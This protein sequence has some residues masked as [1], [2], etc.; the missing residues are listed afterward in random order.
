MCTGLPLRWE[1][2]MAIQVLIGATVAVHYAV[3]VFLMFGGFLAW[4]WQRVLVPH[5]LVVG[6]GLLVIAAPVSCPLTALENFFRA[7]IGRAPLDGGFID[8]YVTGVLY[9]SQD[10]ELVRWLVA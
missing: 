10:V 4:R 1:V 6:W 3:L 5:M 9:P 7:R 2:A 8:T